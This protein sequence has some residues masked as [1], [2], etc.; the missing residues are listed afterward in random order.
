MSEDVIS[1]V[2][3]NF[4]SNSYYLGNSN[5]L[6]TEAT[7][8]DGLGEAYRA[9]RKNTGQQVAIT[10]LSSSSTE[11]EQARCYID[12]FEREPLRCSRS[13]HTNSVRRLDRGRYQA[14]YLYAVFET[15]DALASGRET[16]VIR[17]A[18]TP[19]SLCGESPSSKPNDMRASFLSNVLPAIPMTHHFSKPDQIMGQAC[20]HE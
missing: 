15:V 7:R 3:I 14:H 11:T 19:A 18:K 12:H 17:S 9:K 16:A 1:S 5:C 8:Q 10:L 2:E 6:L 20:M 4:E 13:Q